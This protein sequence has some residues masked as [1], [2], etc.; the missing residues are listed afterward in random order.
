M[1]GKAG[2]LSC[3]PETLREVGPQQRS[4]G[5]LGTVRT[6]AQ[7][8]PP[9][10]DHN[11]SYTAS[12]F[13]GPAHLLFTCHLCSSSQQVAGRLSSPHVRDKELEA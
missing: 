13:S 1:A 5:C 7:V 12:V 9:A 8:S 2:N 3:I 11:N 10:P 4:R 6:K